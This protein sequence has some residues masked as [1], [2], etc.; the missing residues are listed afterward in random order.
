MAAV[1]ATVPSLIVPER[2]DVV[3]RARAR[4][5]VRCPPIYVVAIA[6]VIGD[7]LGSCGFA[8][9][10]WIAIYLSTLALGLF[11]IRAPSFGVAICAIAI[12][13]A[14]TLPAHR[15]MAPAFDPR[16][17]RN[18]PE[19]SMVLVE[20]D[21]IREVERFPDKMRLYIA[22]ER[23]TDERGAVHSVDGAL[24]LTMLH[25]GAFR[26]G[27]RVRFQGRIRFPRNFGNPGEFDYEGFM[28]REGI[29]AT[30][31]AVKGNRRVDVEVL[32][33]HRRY[34]GSAIEDI[35]RH[36]ALFIDRNLDDPAASEM[37]ARIASIAL[38]GKMR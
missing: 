25:R 35:R 4:W 36:I 34:P 10:L 20:G 33:H 31:L 2:D 17:I 27:D 6:I 7:A 1:A 30:M 15:M 11:L 28:R 37:R 38:P 29:D 26:L 16:S 21:L 14:S 24:R 8:V 5:F 13:A 18:I 32:A 9:S 22:V 3:R 23:V 19:G 12:A